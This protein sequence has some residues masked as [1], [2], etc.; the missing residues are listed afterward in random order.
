MVNTTIKETE[1][2]Q[3]ILGRLSRE[4]V[5]N[6]PTADTKTKRQFSRAM[7]A[8]E[9]ARAEFDALNDMKAELRR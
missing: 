6:M 5:L 4:T 1:D 2:V 3:N 9:K 7:I 8:L